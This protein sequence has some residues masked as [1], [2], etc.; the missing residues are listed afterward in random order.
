MGLLSHVRGLTYFNY[1][2]M[3]LL[4]HRNGL[5]LFKP[6]QKDRSYPGFPKTA[7]SNATFAKCKSNSTNEIGEGRK[8][9]G[10]SH[11]ARESL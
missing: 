10:S 3:G 5:T 9:G 2:Q 7:V 4:S 8:N 6:S 11:L 1:R